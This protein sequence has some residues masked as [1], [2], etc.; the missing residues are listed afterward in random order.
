MRL[1]AEGKDIGGEEV[2][3]K[4]CPALNREAYF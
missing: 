4:G 3:R 2:G 1:G